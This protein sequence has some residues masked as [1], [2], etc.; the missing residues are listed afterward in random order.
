MT[1]FGLTTAS[2][3]FFSA[4]HSDGQPPLHRGD[5]L[6]KCTY[7]KA[8]FDWMKL[9]LATLK[10]VLLPEKRGGMMEVW[11]GRAMSEIKGRG[12]RLGLWATGGELL[13]PL[14]AWS[15]SQRR[16]GQSWENWALCFQ[17]CW[18]TLQAAMIMLVTSKWC[19]QQS[20]FDFC[21]MGLAPDFCSGEKENHHQKQGQ[22]D[23]KITNHHHKDNEAQWLELAR[24]GENANSN[25]QS[26]TKQTRWATASLFLVLHLIC[27][28]GWLEGFLKK[29]GNERQQAYWRLL[30]NH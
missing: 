6:L 12:S 13:A 4:A 21:L 10:A 23:M 3:P 8:V 17:P 20:P 2:Q 1:L 14:V 28:A 11:P 7:S 25:P 22:K 18:L 5:A 9:R 30:N 24:N 26:T 16:S 19:V 15:V 29:R 27:L